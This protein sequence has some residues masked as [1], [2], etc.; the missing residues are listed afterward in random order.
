MTPG[1]LHQLVGQ[2]LDIVGAA[3]RVQHLTDRRF[4]LKVKLG[5]AGD[6]RR[7]VG[8]QR[9]GFI[10]GVGVQG[11]GVAQR[12]RQRLDAGAGDI[13]ERVLLG[14]APTRGLAMGPQ[15]HRLVVLGIELLDD[16]GP[17][18]PP[19][20]HLGHFHEVVHADGPEERQPGREGVD[21]HAGLDA[22]AHVLQTVRQRVAQFQIRRRAR[23]LHVIAGDRDA[24]ELRHLLGRIGEDVA[25]DADRRIGWID[26]GIAHH[27]LFQNIVL[28]GAGELLVGN[29]LFFSGDNVERQH[30]QHRAVHGHRY[31]H[32][33]ERDAAEQDFHIEQRI[34]RHAGLADV[35]DHAL[36]VGV[37][38]AMGGQIEGD[39]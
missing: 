4:I 26:I 30:R 25:D 36:V 10:Q 29:A 11:L 12:R 8:W 32:L 27:V 23:F 34:N 15:G 5:V 7:E 18:Q 6:A 24:V 39:G 17:Q 14:Q 38:A 9:D 37:I 1:S 35:A 22:G 33:I 19:G 28:N 2:R 21:V 31:R 3:P 13:V 20:P 16:L